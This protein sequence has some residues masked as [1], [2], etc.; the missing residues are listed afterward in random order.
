MSIC[1]AA[2][3]DPGDGEGED[4]GDEGRASSGCFFFGLV[5]AFFFRAAFFGF[6]FGFALA[7]A[8]LFVAVFVFGGGSEAS[9][10]PSPSC[11]GPLASVVLA[12]PGAGSEASPPSCCDAALAR[13][14]LAGLRRGFT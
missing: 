1:A 6:A 14:P 13:P 12:C 7:F 5:A 10:S 8:L 3:G 4:E 2:G 9:F 11:C